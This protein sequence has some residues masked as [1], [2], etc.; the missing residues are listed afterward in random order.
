M[1]LPSSASQWRTGISSGE[2][3]R[4]G[5]E[6]VNGGLCCSYTF[7][8]VFMYACDKSN[9]KWKGITLVRVLT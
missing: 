3:A 5:L 8:T 6:Q 7:Y 9:G 2:N 4:D 1:V